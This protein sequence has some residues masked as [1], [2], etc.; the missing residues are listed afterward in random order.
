MV[1]AH[2]G[3]AG[4]VGEDGQLMPAASSSHAVQIPAAL[5]VTGFC[6]G[7]RDSQRIGGNEMWVI[8]IQPKATNGTLLSISQ[9]DVRLEALRSVGGLPLM[10]PP[11]LQHGRTHVVEI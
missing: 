10:P 5:A 6:I 8:D 3:D 7:R 1:P 9:V 4:S 11:I 2:V